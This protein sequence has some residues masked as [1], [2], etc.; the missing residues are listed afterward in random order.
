MKS[1]HPVVASPSL[2]ALDTQTA[3]LRRPHLFGDNRR[4]Q[5]DKPVTIRGWANSST[6]VTITSGSEIRTGSNVR[7]GE[8]WLRGGLSNREVT[9]RAMVDASEIRFLR[10]PK[11]APITPQRSTGSFTRSTKP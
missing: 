2:P 4:L 3:E 7:V 1:T 6:Q 9:L 10:P 8:P 11:I 5:R